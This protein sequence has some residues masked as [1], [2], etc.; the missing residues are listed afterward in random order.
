MSF[1][2]SSAGG[3]FC[4]VADCWS[5]LFVLI[6]FLSI[7]Y[8]A[9][10]VCYKINNVVKMIGYVW[11][12]VVTV[13]S[14]VIVAVHTCLFTVFCAVF[15]GLM[16]FGLLYVLNKNKMVIFKT[17]VVEKPVPVVEKTETIEE[18]EDALEKG[19]DFA[20]AEPVEEIQIDP[21]EEVELVEVYEEPEAQTE[22]QPEPVVEEPVPETYIFDENLGRVIE[23]EKVQPV[24]ES[25]I[26]VKQEEPKA[27]VVQEEK[28]AEPVVEEM[29]VPVHNKFTDIVIS[30]IEG[31]PEMEETA[32]KSREELVKELKNRPVM[33][34][35]QQVNFNTNGDE[36]K[37]RVKAKKQ[38]EKP[39]ERPKINHGYQIETFLNDE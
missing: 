33:V 27:P 30:Q 20:E 34:K 28:K 23:P 21:V 14:V 10:C 22:V 37:T 19:E 15:T 36:K 6:N 7:F 25:A 13:S 3:F 8:L 2:L 17:E 38:E 16:L 24:Q 18:I 32:E 4:G 5:W 26:I 9:F 11:S 1:L 35:Y 12:G 31:M 29:I 39:V